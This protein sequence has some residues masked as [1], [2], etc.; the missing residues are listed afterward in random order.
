MSSQVSLDKSLIIFCLITNLI[1]IYFKRY[2]GCFN[3]ISGCTYFSHKGDG[4]KRGTCKENFLCHAD[5][6]CK[7]ICTVLG[8]IGDGINRGSCPE[9]RLCFSDGTCKIA[10]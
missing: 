9:G 7:P 2:K 10:G 4:T 3:H 6:S 1:T 8:S 5:G